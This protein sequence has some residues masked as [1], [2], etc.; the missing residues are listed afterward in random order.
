MSSKIP[1]AIVRIIA[2]NVVCMKRQ[3]GL[4]GSQAGRPGIKQRHEMVVHVPHAIALKAEF[5]DQV[6]ED[7]LNLLLGEGDLRIRSPGGV[8]FPGALAGRE[9]VTVVESIDGGRGTR[10]PVCTVGDL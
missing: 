7:V 9:S 10:G 5:I 6:Q 4:V 1:T 3:K 8:W 2:P